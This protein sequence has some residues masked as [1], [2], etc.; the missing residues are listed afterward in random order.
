MRKG[1]WRRRERD[2]GQVVRHRFEDP[3]AAAAVHGSHRSSGLLSRAPPGLRADGL[4]HGADARARRP[5]RSSQE[6]C[7]TTSSRIQRPRRR[8]TRPASK[9]SRM[10]G[11]REEPHTS[12]QPTS[13]ETPAV[14]IA[15]RWSGRTKDSMLGQIGR[16]AMLRPACETQRIRKLPG[17][18]PAT[19]SA[20]AVWTV[21]HRDLTD[22]G[23]N[24][25]APLENACQA[26]WRII[27]EDGEEKSDQPPTDNRSSDC[28]TGAHSGFFGPHGSFRLSTASQVRSMRQVLLMR[29]K[30]A[31]LTNQRPWKYARGTDADGLNLSH[32]H[33]DL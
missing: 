31:P 6:T 15:V 32:R 30:Q 2:R 23:V 3:R 20:F 29:F 28:C 4:L 14:R 12:P 33:V 22:S 18:W 27:I 9:R 17:E 11:H 21:A 8:K 26:R 1:G 13:R 7:E 5:N 25:P 16:R 19:A 24:E 10:P